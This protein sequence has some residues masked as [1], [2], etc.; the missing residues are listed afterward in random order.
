MLT[1]D[2]IHEA[3]ERIYRFVHR[4]PVLTSSAFDERAGCKVFFKCENFQ[5]AGAFK[6][7]GATNRIRALNDEERARGVVAFSSGNHAQAVALASRDAGVRAVIA[8][9][10]DAPKAKV[11]AT[12]GYGAEVVFYDRMRD[13]REQVARDLASRNG[14]VLVSPFDD[15]LVM[16]GQGTCAVELFEDVGDLDAL[17]VPYGGGGL[18]AGASVAARGLSSRVACLRFSSNDNAVVEW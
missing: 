14:S 18:F 3:R 1:V 8:M 5:R 17:V 11:A 6:M 12:K 7:R 4:T 15:Y 13:D 9:P 10:N 2:L 16:A